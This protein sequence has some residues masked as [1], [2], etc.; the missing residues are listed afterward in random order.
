MHYGDGMKEEALKQARKEA[1]EEGAFEYH[2]PLGPGF[3]FS[4]EPGAQNFNPYSKYSVQGPKTVTFDYSE[5][6]VDAQ[7]NR[8]SLRKR[9]RI[10]E[11]LH[12]RR[13]SRHFAQQQ[14]GMRRQQQRYNSAFAR[15]SND[16]VIL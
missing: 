2:S 7:S 13:E 12:G 10:V 14:D 5:A 4:D 6:Y 3:T 9:E 11:D 16:C 15:S 8:E 1:L